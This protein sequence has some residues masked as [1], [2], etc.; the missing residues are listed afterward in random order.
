MEPRSARVG[1]LTLGYLE[2]GSGPLVVLLHGFPDTPHGWG[3]SLDTLPQA[4]LR[5]VAP[6]LR[7]Y[8]PSSPAP[9]DRYD[10]KRLGRDV[11]GLLDALGADDAVVVGHDWGALAAYAAASLAP[12]RVRRLVTVCVPHPAAGKPSL[13]A[14]WHLRHFL[15]LRRAKAGQALRRGDFAY[16]DTL[17]A[18]WSTTPVRPGD[19][20]AAKAALGPPG[21]AEA[22]CAYYRDF[23]GRLPEALR[24]PLSVPTA[25]LFGERDVFG[26]AEFEAARRLHAGPYALLGFD[27]AHFPQRERPDEFARALV[28]AVKG[29]PLEP[30]P[31]HR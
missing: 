25:A 30:S 29:E 10:L 15:T 6:F 17:V 19:T 9:D 3:L 5:V 7:G 18:R 31:A 28:R 22:A 8:A 24:R 11:L 13:R 12:E 14:A 23:D 4:G 16:L 27:A 1:E 20:Q 2:R 26:R 21:H